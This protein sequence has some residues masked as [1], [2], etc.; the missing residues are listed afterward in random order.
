M[1]KNKETNKVRSLIYFLTHN[2]GLTRE[3]QAKRDRLLARD[4]VEPT[5]YQIIDIEEKKTNTTHDK[6]E[7]IPPHELRMFL[8]KFNQDE[9]LKYTCH[10]I[11]TDETIEEIN[12]YCKTDKY[13]FE[14]HSKIIIDRFKTLLKEQNLKNKNFTG[15]LSAY[16][17]ISHKPWSTLDVP[18]WWNHEELIKWSK[19][20]ENII[21]SPGRNIAKKQKKNGYRLPKPIKSYLTGER[22]DTFSKLVIY[23]KSLFHIRRDNSLRNILSYQNKERVVD[24]INVSFSEDKFN[25]NIELLTDVDKLVQ[26]YKA[27]LKICKEANKDNEKNVELSFYEVADKVIFAMHDKGHYYGK[28]LAAATQRIGASQTQ[29]IKNQINGLCN[30]YIEADFDENTS[31]R[32]DLWTKT[33]S[34]LGDKVNI[35]SHK[36]DKV[37][38]VK[39]ILEFN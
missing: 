6:V 24:G 31:A 22:I 1:A 35:P 14:R 27:I 2:K 38:G 8:Y 37:D 29:L 12:K 26:A 15:L 33:S 4:C 23:F 30:L 9:I 20:N 39:Y 21:L 3:Q 25:D 34:P 19:E 18:I 36:I 32:I 16:L 11:D 10:E 5:A 17:G 7:Y 28:T 13:D